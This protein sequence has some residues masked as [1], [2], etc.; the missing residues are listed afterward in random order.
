MYAI[1][2]Y[3]VQRITQFYY[4][5]EILMNDSAKP[6]DHGLIRSDFPGGCR[7]TSYNVCYTKL[8]R[9]R[10]TATVSSF[11]ILNKT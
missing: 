2:S 9:L 5:T 3:Y 1:R 10:I 6:G 4:G 8:L 7:I 11:K